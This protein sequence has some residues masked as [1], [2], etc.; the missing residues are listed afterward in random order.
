LTGIPQDDS[1]I[2]PAKS[3][4]GQTALAHHL[5]AAADDHT[6][7]SFTDIFSPSDRSRLNGKVSAEV[8][9]VDLTSDDGL[10]KVPV[11]TDF[12]GSHFSDFLSDHEQLV[13][14]SSDSCF[15]SSPLTQI[16]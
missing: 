12:D 7:F 1:F 3:S 4:D 16:S 11:A 15:F 8:E 13:P 5:T 10:F 14:T 9:L 2:L 6:H